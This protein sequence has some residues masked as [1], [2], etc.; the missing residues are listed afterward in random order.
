MVALCKAMAALCKAIE[1]TNPF[2]T[3]IVG[4]ALKKGV[5]AEEAPDA[6][7]CSARVCTRTDINR[8]KMIQLQTPRVRICRLFRAIVPI[9][10]PESVRFGGKRG[11][12]RIK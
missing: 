12:P 7:R 3:G 11:Y 4:V 8:L 6:Y 10:A 5:C 1:K 9:R 2:Q